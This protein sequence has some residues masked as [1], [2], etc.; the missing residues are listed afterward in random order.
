LMYGFAYLYKENPVW[1]E[2]FSAGLGAVSIESMATNVGVQ[3]QKY[4]ELLKTGTWAS[5][6]LELLA[7]FALLTLVFTKK[8]RYII[9]PLL[10]LMHISFG[11]AIHIGMFW[12][13]P[14]VGLILFLPNGWWKLLPKTK[15]NSNVKVYFDDTCAICQTAVCPFIPKTQTQGLSTTSGNIAELSA[16]ENT[17][18]VEKN[19]VIYTHVEAISQLLKLYWFTWPV[20]WFITLPVIKHIARFKYN[21]IAKHRAQLSKIFYSFLISQP[22]IRSGVVSQLVAFAALVLVIFWNVL[23]FPG[24]SLSN[25]LE[26]STV[27]QNLVQATNLHQKWSMFSPIPR[28][29]WG[30]FVGEGVTTSGQKVDVYNFKKQIPD[31]NRPANLWE[32]YHNSAGFNKY[33]EENVAISEFHQKGYARYTC[34]EWNRQ[35]EGD[36]DKLATFKIRYYQVNVTSDGT[37][38][39]IPREIVNWNC[40]G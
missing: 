12:W 24:N 20:G 15:I 39:P 3:L 8:V 34:R 31:E 36:Q 5:V 2:N 33:M 27:E 13:V 29:T 32:H 4:P 30:W 37:K 22:G 9:L 18:V 16:R 14:L 17:I 38:I 10:A 21:I 23:Y 7:P 11:A 1:R 35:F 40:L 28:T 6:T 25:T 19:G 26:L